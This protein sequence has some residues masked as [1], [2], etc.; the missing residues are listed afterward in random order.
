MLQMIEWA[1]AKQAI[2]LFYIPVARIILT[3]FVFEKFE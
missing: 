3:I 1:I 2:D